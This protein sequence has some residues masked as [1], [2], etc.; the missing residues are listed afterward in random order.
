MASAPSAPP[1]V[2]SDSDDLPAA[3]AAPSQPDVLPKRKRG[4][5]GGRR[6]KLAKEMAALKLKSAGGAS[7]EQRSGPSAAVVD[8]I[9][10]AGFWALRE[11]KRLQGRPST[12]GGDGFR[13]YFLDNLPTYQVE[14]ILKA[15]KEEATPLPGAYG[16]RGASAPATVRSMVRLAPSATPRAPVP[17]LMSLPAAPTP[18]SATL[19]VA[20]APAPAVPP[21]TAA[22]AP[23]TA[24]SGYGRTCP[25]WLA[26]PTM[27][28]AKL[29]NPS[30][31]GPFSAP[32]A[33]GAGVV[34]RLPGA[35]A[36]PRAPWSVPSV[37]ASEEM[38][39]DLELGKVDVSIDFGKD[40]DDV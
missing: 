15:A 25:P 11:Y 40:D 27:A 37:P 34:L 35:C 24:R 8:D 26:P 39:I 31:Q 14:V 17:A 36:A 7:A 10:R 6:V 16:A 2:S 12:G 33:L 28:E 30:Y 23:S 13:R 22:T 20:P 32:A 38:D 21:V 29:R 19:L 3:P 18:S 9:V 5:R 4:C 1:A